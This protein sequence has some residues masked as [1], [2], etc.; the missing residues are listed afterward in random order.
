MES[1]STTHP[2]STVCY[3]SVLQPAAIGT[4]LFILSLSLSIVPFVLQPH[5]WWPHCVESNVFSKR[6]ADLYIMQ[7]LTCP[8]QAESGTGGAK[9]T[10]KIIEWRILWRRRRRRECAIVAKSQTHSFITEICHP[11]WPKNNNYG[12]PTLFYILHFHY[13]YTISKKPFSMF[14]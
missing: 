7:H 14:Y 11:P 13:W 12:P 5:R 6:T 10:K 3:S 8:C 4:P 9:I 1:R 2:Y